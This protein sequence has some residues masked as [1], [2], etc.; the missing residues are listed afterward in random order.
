MTSYLMVCWAAQVR[1][2]VLTLAALGIMDEVEEMG[3]KGSKK[4]KARHLDEDFVV[5]SLP[6]DRATLTLCSRSYTL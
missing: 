2:A 4:K 3:M 5:S 6:P 1:G